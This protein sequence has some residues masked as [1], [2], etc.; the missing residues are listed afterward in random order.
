MSEDTRKLHE[1]GYAQELS[2]KVSRFSNF[3]ISFTIISILSGCLTLYYYGL[4]HG[5]PPTMLWGWIIVGG[6]VMFVALAMAEVCSSFPTA[7][8]LYYWAAKLAPGKSGPAVSWFTGWFNLIGQ[9]AITSGISFGSVFSIGAWLAL[10]TGD[11]KWTSPG[12]LLTYLGIVLLIQ[13]LLNS[14]G[15]RLVALLNDIS[16]WWHI[17]FV[18][19]I[20]I[21]MFVAPTSGTHQSA[22][23]LF[24]SEGFHNL[25]GFAA[26]PF[27][28]LLGLL[29]A[30]YTF[31]GYDASAHMTEETVNAAVA[32]PRGIVDSIWVSWIFGFLLLL[33]V[34]IAI[35]THF[36]VNLS[37]GLTLTSYDDVATNAVPWAVIFEY[38]AGRAAAEFLILAVFV[39]QFFCGM[40]SVTANSRMIYAFSRDGAVPFHGFWHRINKRTRTPVNSVWFGAIGAFILA[41]PSYWNSVAYAA[42]TAVAVIGLYIAYMLPVLMRRINS[43][44]FVPGPWQLG[45]WS[46]A[47]GWIMIVWIIFIGVLFCLPSASAGNP[48]GSEFTWSAVNYAP[49]TLLVVVGGTGIW[50]LVSARKWF[51]GPK[52]QGTPEELAEIERDLERAG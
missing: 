5:G 10:Y 23:F 14:F 44:A 9:V 26:A 30:Q 45:R 33:A 32:G 41:I 34:S 15:V 43:K 46:F 1:M 49:I 36:P 40:S 35:P 50:Y 28:F 21:V 17:V 48:F 20:L 24:G 42:I 7:G 39:A 16:V 27:V 38:N 19:V 25:S 11:E 31:T 51:K 3:A 52:V 4:Q 29:N 12:H 8:G 13:G 18:L 37:G 2:R 22:S 6:L 47:I